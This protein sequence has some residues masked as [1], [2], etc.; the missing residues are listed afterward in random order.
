MPV[1]RPDIFAQKIS[2]NGKII[3]EVVVEAEIKQTLFSEHTTHQLVLMSEYLNHRK[4]KKIK[5]K[6]YLLIPKGKQALALARSLL[7]S[8]VLSGNHIL[9]LQR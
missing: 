9:I 5:I 2:K 7:N 8:L 6:G 1:F 4:N 3:E